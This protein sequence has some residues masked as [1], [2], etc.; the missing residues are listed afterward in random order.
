MNN[1]HEIKN[2]FEGFLK[3]NRIKVREL[4]GAIR[5]KMDIYYEMQGRLDD[6]IDNDQAILKKRLDDL[7]DEVYEDLLDEFE[8]RLVNDEVMESEAK[9]LPQE[10]KDPNEAIL[11][12]IYASG[13]RDELTRSYLLSQGLKVDFSL[14]E[15]R[16]G[17]YLLHRSSVF[18]LRFRLVKTA[19]KL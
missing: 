9:P 7:A 2:L 18:H 5:E 13:Q 11:D 10:K 12:A 17:P 15:I 8:D 14:W 3:T 1:N 4:P 19:G 16:V 6:T